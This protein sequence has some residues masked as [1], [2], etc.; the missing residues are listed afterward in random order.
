MSKAKFITQEVSDD[1]L[2]KYQT[3]PTT[4]LGTGFLPKGKRV[5]LEY[6]D[7]PTEDLRSKPK[8]KRSRSSSSMARSSNDPACAEDADIFCQ[9]L[10]LSTEVEQTILFVIAVDT[11]SPEENLLNAIRCYGGQAL[12][13]YLYDQAKD[14]YLVHCREFLQLG[15]FPFSYSIGLKGVGDWS[16]NVPVPS[17]ILEKYMS[18]QQREILGQFKTRYSNSRFE[19]QFVQ[20]I[21]CN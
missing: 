6:G 5:V 12:G 16:A 19:I 20:M 11:E 4:P 1:H 10:N 8:T 3:M 21:G 2:P 13:G 14:S 15:N 17:K 18:P 9:S 7:E